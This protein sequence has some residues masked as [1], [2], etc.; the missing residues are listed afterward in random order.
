M[1]DP[2]EARRVVSRR[3]KYKCVVCEK[4]VKDERFEVDHIK[5]LFEAN[6]DPTFWQAPNLRTLCVECHKDKTR[7]DMVRFR[8]AKKTSLTLETDNP[9][10]EIP[11]A[12]HTCET[13]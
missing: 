7:E 9:E 2:K 13:P 10:P 4:S 1:N 5:P 3:D 8:E 11:H 12:A 6:G